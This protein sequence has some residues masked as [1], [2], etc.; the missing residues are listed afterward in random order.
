MRFA[1]TSMI[2]AASILSRRNSFQMFRIHTAT[3]QAGT[4]NTFTSGNGKSM[5][6]M[7]KLVAGRDGADKGQEGNHM[8]LSFRLAGADN[9]QRIAVVVDS[10]FPQPAAGFGIDDDVALEPGYLYPVET[11]WLPY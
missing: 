8:P 6:N 10:A 1:P 7:I 3:V 9:V 2:L 4:T 5:A 11:K